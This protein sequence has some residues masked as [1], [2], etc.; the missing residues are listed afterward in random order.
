MEQLVKIDLASGALIHGSFVPP[1]PPPPPPPPG[2]HHSTCSALQNNTDVIGPAVVN[3]HPISTRCGVTLE[4]C[5]AM[6]D[7]DD[8]CVAF[9]LD[10]D[11]NWSGT[12]VGKTLCATLTLSNS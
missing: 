4:Q 2:K 11:A 6:C 3:T 1:P 7:G 5:C 10:P 12:C 9:T 8:K